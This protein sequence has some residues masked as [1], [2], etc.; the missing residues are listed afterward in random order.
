M[1][2]QRQ[3]RLATNNSQVCH[4]SCQLCIKWNTR[5]HHEETVRNL[6]RIR[7]KKDIWLHSPGRTKKEIPKIKPLDT[8]RDQALKKSCHSSERKKPRSFDKQGIHTWG[9]MKNKKSEGA[10]CVGK[11]TG[12]WRTSPCVTHE[13]SEGAC[14]AAQTLRRLSPWVPALGKRAGDSQVTVKQAPPSPI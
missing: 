8:P 14:V 6:A 7:Q 4:F 12:T 11:L 10:P 9:R 13:A 1:R 3:K 5:R 2:T